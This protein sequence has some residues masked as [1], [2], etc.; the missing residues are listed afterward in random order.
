MPVLPSSVLHL[1]VW[2][3]PAPATV[4]T[5][6]GLEEPSM[7]RTKFGEAGAELGQAQA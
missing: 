4:L 6:L 1:S 7:V 2:R 3:R 5:G